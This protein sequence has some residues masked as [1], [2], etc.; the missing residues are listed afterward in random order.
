MNIKRLGKSKSNGFY[1]KKIQPN[2]LQ[3]TNI[4]INFYPQKNERITNL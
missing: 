1:T 2:V 3:N 4:D